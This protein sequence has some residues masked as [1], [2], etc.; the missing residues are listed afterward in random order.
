MLIIEDVGSATHHAIHDHSQRLVLEKGKRKRN[1][2]VRCV[3]IR[4]VRHCL[5]S[6]SAWS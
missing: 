4:N 6:M 2:S 5:Y 1:S 3:L